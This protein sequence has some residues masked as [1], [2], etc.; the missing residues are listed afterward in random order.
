[1]FPPE[2]LNLFPQNVF[3]APD[4]VTFHEEAAR[5]A[6]FSIIAGVDEVG[7]G[8]LAGPVVAAAVILP[9][10]PLLPGVKDS[11]LMTPKSREK[12]FEAI[13]FEALSAAVGVVSRAYIDRFNI[14]KASLEA[15]ARAVRSLDPQP[16][17]LLVDGIYPVSL[18][19]PQQCLKKGDQVSL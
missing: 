14:L 17:F 10:S 19:I 11:K 9:E 2:N 4:R 3:R 6:G 16:E 1:M 18:P 5:E 13:R 8:P 12:A 7:R 15:M